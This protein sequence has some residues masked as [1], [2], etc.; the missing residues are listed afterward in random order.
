MTTK[1]NN[2]GYTLIEQYLVSN[3]EDENTCKFGGVITI[4]EEGKFICSNH[5][6]ED[7]NTEETDEEN[8]PEETMPWLYYVGEHSNVWMYVTT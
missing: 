3:T 5:I 1:T 8:Y 6:D 7:S 4:N 2:K